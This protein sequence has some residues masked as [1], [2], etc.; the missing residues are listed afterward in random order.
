MKTAAEEL[1]E[2][3]RE[4]LTQYDNLVGFSQDEHSMKAHKLLGH[5]EAALEDARNEREGIVPRDHLKP[6]VRDQ[7]ERWA[8][9]VD[10]LPVPQ[11]K[12]EIAKVFDHKTQKPVQ[13]VAENGLTE[14]GKPHLM[15]CVA[16]QGGEG[17]GVLF[18]PNPN[19]VGVITQLMKICLCCRE[20][21]A[22]D[23]QDNLC[24]TCKE[25]P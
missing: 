8:E 21:F 24:P 6:E 4:L 20:H 22:G 23:D 13:F 18:E 17:L 11:Q 7:L 9:M 10:K 12:G 1:V 2:G 25:L 14:S 15:W 3:L 19:N 16:G 5:Y